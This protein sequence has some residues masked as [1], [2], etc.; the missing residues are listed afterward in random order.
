MAWLEHKDVWRDELSIVFVG[1]EHISFHTCFSGFRGERADDVVG[2]KA[3]GLQD[4]D[5]HGLEDLLY[6]RYAEL[7][8]FRCLFALSLVGWVSLVA[9]RLAVVESHAEMCGMLFVDDLPQRV[10][11]PQD[12][13]GVQALGVDG[14]SVDKGIVRPEND[15]VGVE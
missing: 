6:I 15:G 2:L 8:V 5:V 10:A 4:G 11:E 7:D 12:S 14:R 13:R 9:E 3:V 1:R